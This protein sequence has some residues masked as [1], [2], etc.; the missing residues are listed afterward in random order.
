MGDIISV[1]EFKRHEELK[2]DKKCGD[3]DTFKKEMEKISMDD[4]KTNDTELIK[5]IK[6]SILFLRGHERIDDHYNT[7]V[8]PIQMLIDNPVSEELIVWCK[9]DEEDSWS[10]LI[11]GISSVNNGT[12]PDD[13]V[14]LR[15]SCENNA[16]SQFIYGMLYGFH[17]DKIKQ[18][19]W[20]QK[21]A[22]QGYLPASMFLKPIL[23]EQSPQSEIVF[24]KIKSDI[25]KSC[26]NLNKKCK[27][28]YTYPQTVEEYLIMKKVYDTIILEKINECFNEETFI[29]KDL[30]SIII[31]YL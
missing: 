27:M 2:V 22:D 12:H 8:S 3:V 16:C 15:K 9:E 17:Q 14:L 30:V 4:V 24:N 26:D 13:A 28:S 21:S 19:K 1:E 23:K 7:A 5:V 10:Q 31:S 29:P 11:L 25:E 18:V 20:I 6:I